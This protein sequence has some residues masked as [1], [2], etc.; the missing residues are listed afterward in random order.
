MGLS[1]RPIGYCTLSKDCP[2]SPDRNKL[3]LFLW[4]V[5]IAVVVSGLGLTFSMSE[6]GLSVVSGEGLS[7]CL[8]IGTSCF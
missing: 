2:L 5:T 4:T 1:Y 6:Q 8:L 3:F 7:S